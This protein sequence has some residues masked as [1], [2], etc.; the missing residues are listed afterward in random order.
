MLF[1]FQEFLRNLKSPRRTKML[2]KG[3]GELINQVKEDA[4]VFLMSATI[5]GN[6][7]IGPDNAI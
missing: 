1:L 5:D 4:N 3:L 7:S 6:P 2:N